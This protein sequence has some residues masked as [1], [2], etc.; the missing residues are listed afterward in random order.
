MKLEKY[1]GI[2]LF[3]H[4]CVIV[5]G[6]GGFVCSHAPAYINK[7]KNQFHPPFKKISFNKNLK[8]N[9]GLLANQISQ[10]ENISYNEANRFI[11]ESLSALTNEL[12]LS[13]RF[14]LRNIGTFYHGE[15]NTILFE[16]DETVNYLP[17][18]FGMKIFSSPA[19]KRATLERKI[20]KKL[21]DKVIVPSKDNKEIILVAKRSSPVKYIAA[22]ASVL[23]IIS[24]VFISLKTDLLKNINMA[25]LTLLRKR[26]RRFISLL[27]ILCRI[28]TL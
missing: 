26:Q 23:V 27:K 5:P 10:A 28:L 20:E 1:I 16:Q 3:E 6:F 9:D 2:L 8:N 13:R 24:L 12:N 19:V 14:E 15:E 22:A 17:E 11:S 7:A 18:A 4:D 25:G 21:E